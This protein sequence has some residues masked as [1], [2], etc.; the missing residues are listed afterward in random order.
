MQLGLEPVFHPLQTLSHAFPICDLRRFRCSIWCFYGSKLLAPDLLWTTAEDR[1]L[2]TV[3]PLTL[4]GVLYSKSSSWSQVLDEGKFHSPVPHLVSPLRRQEGQQF[5]SRILGLKDCHFLA[6]CSNFCP[7]E[8]Y[9]S[10]M[11]NPNPA[12]FTRSFPT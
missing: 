11:H 7:M 6:L 1:V 9:Q 2:L 5:P 4:L 12:D 10:T 8:P 3:F